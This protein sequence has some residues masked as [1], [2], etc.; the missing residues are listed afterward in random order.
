[1]YES[2]VLQ[3]NNMSNSHCNCNDKR[4]I[5]EVRSQLLKRE[6]D[7]RWPAQA[8]GEWTP[9][10]GMSGATAGSRPNPQGLR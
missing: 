9:L 3:M 4:R 2:D 5:T 8:H 10:Q 6:E 7:Q 1:M